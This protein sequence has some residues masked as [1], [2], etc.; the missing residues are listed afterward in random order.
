VKAF[1][2]NIIGL[3]NKLHQFDFELGDTFFKHFGTELV[4]G[5][6]FKAVVVLNKHETFMEADFKI[7]GQAHLVC[8][9]SLEP[10]DHPVY[11]DKKIVFKYGEEEGE[12]DDDVVIISHDRASLELGQYMYEF[13][14]LEIPIKRLH[15]KFQ[16][17]EDDENEEGKLIYTSA[18][19]EDKNE[20]EQIDPRWEKLKK[21]K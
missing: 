10:F 13:I 16:D 21:L 9:R 5:G 4:P 7:K 11:V 18:T 2:I 19:E 14:G 15:P 6:Q 3:S 8:D 17:E 12:I 1:S 20:E